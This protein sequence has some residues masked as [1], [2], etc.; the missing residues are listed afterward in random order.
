MH[1]LYLEN[2]SNI[3]KRHEN[4]NIIDAGINNSPKIVTNEGMTRIEN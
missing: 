1:V 4:Q 2:K 3:E